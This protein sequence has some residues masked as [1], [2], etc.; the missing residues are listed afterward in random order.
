MTAV[1]TAAATGRPATAA[2]VLNVTH[3]K[4]FAALGVLA[5]LAWYIVHR[6]ASHR[7][8]A[9]E[10][11]AKVLL[12][13]GGV[14]LAVTVGAVA[15]WINTANDTTANWFT[16]WTGDNTFANRHLGLLTLLAI[17]DVAF[18]AFTT[19]D[20]LAGLKKNANSGGRRAGAR[21]GAAEHTANKYGWFG[22]GPL[23]VTLPAPFGL[24]IMSGLTLLAEW[25]GALLG[26]LV[27]IG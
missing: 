12:V 13:V 8:P 21:W 23:A 20:L 15:D 5:I 6:H 22:L 27:G 2:A 14:I 7:H 4:L 17:V 18:V 10:V 9:G 3:S 26:K 1:I 24:W 25:V 16:A 19:W 11:V